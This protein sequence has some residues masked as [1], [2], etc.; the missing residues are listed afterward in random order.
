LTYPAVI[1]NE[2]GLFSLGGLFNLHSGFFGKV[3]EMRGR[4]VD[5]NGKKGTV[6]YEI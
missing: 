3:M 2:S 5:D 1:L 6:S 4:I